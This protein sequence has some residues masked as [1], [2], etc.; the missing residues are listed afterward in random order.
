MSVIRKAFFLCRYAVHM[1]D[2]ARKELSDWIFF[3]ICFCDT[4]SLFSLSLCSLHARYCAN[5]ILRLNIFFNSF[6]W[7]EKPFIVDLQSCKILL[8]KN[9]QI[10]FCMNICFWDT[11]SLFFRFAVFISKFLH[12][13]FFSF[14]SLSFNSYDKK[15]FLEHKHKFLAQWYFSLEG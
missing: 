10:D 3:Q 9:L 2:F 15:N 14:L 5:R 13:R 12:R 1:Q 7:Y 6:L 4:K 8:E 11:K